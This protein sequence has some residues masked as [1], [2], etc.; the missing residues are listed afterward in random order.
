[1]RMIVTLKYL[2]VIVIIWKICWKIH[3]LM[4]IHMTETQD[5]KQTVMA[6]LSMI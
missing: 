1:M 6:L 4:K 3:Q 2:R 5:L